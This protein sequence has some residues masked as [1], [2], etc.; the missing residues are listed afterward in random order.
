M[1]TLTRWQSQIP[2][3]EQYYH[4]FY[5]VIV[6]DVR[7]TDRNQ[8]LFTNDGPAHKALQEVLI[9]Y[10]I[11]VA[12]VGY[13]QG[14]SDLAA[15]LMQIYF[16]KVTDEK[17]TLYND[18]EV[19]FN[20][21]TNLI[22]WSFYGLLKLTGNDLL[23]KNMDSNRNFIAERAFSLL[24][25]HISPVSK[26]L[27]SVQQENLLFTLSP[28]LLL[29]RRWFP[30]QTLFIIWDRLFCHQDPLSYLRFLMTA[31]VALTF[32]YICMQ[33]SSGGD[34]SAGYNKYLSTLKPERILQVADALLAKVKVD[35]MH[36]Q[37]IF[38]KYPEEPL[39]TEYNP[40]FIKI[41]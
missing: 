26:W 32:P 38:M 23:F 19:E 10:A 22:F 12:D 34:V 9:C 31:T 27:L 18:S 36:T 16:K 25:S 30:L 33:G 24:Q 20:K 29:L 5:S 21:A 1:H 3:Q 6:S 35:M 7:R 40:K 8:S 13:I 41:V 11:L 15:A 28:T 17:V 4:P 2:D 39:E 14:M 37:W